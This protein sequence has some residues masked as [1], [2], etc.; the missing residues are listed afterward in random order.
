MQLG[1]GTYTYTWAIGI[2]GFPPAQPLDAPGLL[3][4]AIRLGVKVVQ[5]AD[6]LPLHKLSPVA[7]DSLRKAARQSE[8]QI[9]VGTRG[10][11][12]AHLLTYLAIAQELG[13]PILRV[14]ID[15]T[16]QHPGMPEIIATLR[17][18]EGAFRSAGIMLAIENHDRFT[19]HEFR[20]L[21]DTLGDW[22]SICLDTVN[23]F[24]ALEN[25]RTVIDT[26]APVAINL[27]IKDFTIRRVEHQMGFVIEGCPAGQ[28]R[29]AIQG[30]VA[31]LGK[32]G[33]CRS[34]VLELWTP[35]EP[36]LD[37]TLVKEA[38]WADE[39]IRYLRTLIAE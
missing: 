17:D 29:L 34:A 27:H 33:R 3:H 39:S 8:L 2:A 10:I 25:P 26:L 22:T 23:S 1:I 24:G 5:F 7:L 4:Q 35:P 12:Q 16:E 13:S 28:G 19:C 9:E 18:V 32:F 14:V 20:T 31:Q 11:A 30:I 6:N 21:I 36:T 15:T 38:H 37:E